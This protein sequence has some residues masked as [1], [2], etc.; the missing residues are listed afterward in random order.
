MGLNLAI[1]THLEVCDPCRQ[2]AER[3]TD[4]HVDKNKENASSEPSSLDPA[5]QVFEMFGKQVQLP[6]SIARL[7]QA[8]LKWREV[9]KGGYSALLKA[10]G[11]IR[12]A[13]VHLEAGAVVPRHY[14]TH[15]ETMQM[16]DGTLCDDFDCYGTTDFVI[17][18]SNQD[19]ALMT[20]EGCYCL[21]VI[22]GPVYFSLGWERLRNPLI[23]LR[24][25]QAMMRKF[26]G[27]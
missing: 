26:I 21:I 25:F 9:T 8:G 18:D 2:L 22:D 17:R 14:H 3:N 16:I 20:Q 1:A 11:G 4:F 7:A 23:T 5:D 12:C 15:T 27:R 10:D 13:L 6:P 19:H 24:H